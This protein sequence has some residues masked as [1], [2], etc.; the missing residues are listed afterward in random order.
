VDALSAE[1]AAITGPEHVLTD[2]DLTGGYATDWTRRFR[3]AARC[4]VRPGA[5]GIGR[6]K[7]AVLHLS[8][9]PV[10]IAVMPAVKPGL[11]RPESSTLR[12]SSHP[13]P[14]DVARCSGDRRAG[15][16]RR[17]PR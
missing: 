11:I 13:E 14:A 10:E 1:L 16:D 8:R 17:P 4:V 6:A 5:H 7:T 2:P 9:S 15:V 12:R 3:G